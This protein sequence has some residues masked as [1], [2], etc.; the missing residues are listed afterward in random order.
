MC[1]Q[2][3]LS[4]FLNLCL[5]GRFWNLLEFETPQPCIVQI[6]NVPKSGATRQK[7]KLSPCKCSIIM[8]VFC[9]EILC[10]YHI[11]QKNLK[12]WKLKIYFTINIFYY[13][14]FRIQKF[15]R[16]NVDLYVWGVKFYILHNLGVGFLSV[17][18]NLLPRVL[19]LG[20]GV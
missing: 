18:L 13:N 4:R 10:I 1:R 6:C 11:Y 16:S 19:F 15:H 2:C 14:I 5:C 20:V 3:A 12:Y 17:I 8:L 7:Y 9:V